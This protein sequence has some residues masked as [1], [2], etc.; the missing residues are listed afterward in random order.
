MRGLAAGVT[1]FES[2]PPIRGWLSLVTDQQAHRGLLVLLIGEPVLIVDCRF[3]GE[4]ISFIPGRRGRPPQYH[5][6]C[7]VK[8][9]NARRRVGDG[10]ADGC[11]MCAGAVP[12]DRRFLCS[13]DCSARYDSVMAVVRRAEHAERRAADLYE[14]G[15]VSTVSASEVRP[16]M[17]EGERVWRLLRSE[18]LGR[19]AVAV[20]RHCGELRPVLTLVPAA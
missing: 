13:P 16:G 18:R 20:A 3:C 2:Q 9:R 12:V 19:V 5:S 7:V 17:T 15:Q 1:V 6:D 14:P 11:R 8:A 10:R 4:P